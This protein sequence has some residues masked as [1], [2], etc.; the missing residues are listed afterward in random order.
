MTASTRASMMPSHIYNLG[1]NEV[2]KAKKV[3][4]EPCNEMV[5][6]VLQATKS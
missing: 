1:E 3:E 6:Y 2:C 4:E 5:I